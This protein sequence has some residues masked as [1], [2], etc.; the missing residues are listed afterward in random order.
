MEEN[1]SAS[2]ALC[3]PQN[4]TNVNMFNQIQNNL[5]PKKK[6]ILSWEMKHCRRTHIPTSTVT[7]SVINVDLSVY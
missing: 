3:W 7:V 1:N 5:H 6:K 4:E 2:E